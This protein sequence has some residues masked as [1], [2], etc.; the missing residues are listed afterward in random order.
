MSCRTTVIEVLTF[1]PHDFL[2][3]FENF[4]WNFKNKREVK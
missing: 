1:S 2:R 3:F 4:G